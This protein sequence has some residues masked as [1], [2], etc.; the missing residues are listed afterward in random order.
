[1]ST[2]HDR[3]T[4]PDLRA[5]L[6]ELTVDELEFIAVLCDATA[7]GERVAILRHQRA[8]LEGL[9]RKIDALRASKEGA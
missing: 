2:E 5:Q 3:P 7:H 1:M 9:Q 8:L 6:D 4:S